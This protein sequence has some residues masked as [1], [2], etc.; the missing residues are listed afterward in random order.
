MKTRQILEQQ[1]AAQGHRRRTGRDLV[2]Y[3]TSFSS[4]LGM[5]PIRVINISRLGLMGRTSAPLAKGDR[6]IIDLPHVKTIE[7][8]VRWAEGGRI[9]TEFAATMAVDDYATMI[10]LIPI[11]R[12]RW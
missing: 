12:N 6:V 2:D 4:R 5:E 7:A 11:R 9:G 1:D 8:L 10:A 3:T